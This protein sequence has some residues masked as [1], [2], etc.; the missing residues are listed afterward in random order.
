MDS[1]QWTLA[2][3][4]LDAMPYEELHAFVRW[5]GNGV[6]PIKAAKELFPN[7]E[8]GFV[9]VTVNLR[10]YAWNKITAISCRLEGKIDAALQYEGIC[11]RIYSELPESA[12]W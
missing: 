6:R 5:I 11:D 3:L 12:R 10:N 4:N 8:V 1:K 9:R 7:R 2:E